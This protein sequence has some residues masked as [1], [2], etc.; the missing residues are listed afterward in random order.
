MGPSSEGR[1]D[2]HA[3][4]LDGGGDHVSEGLEDGGRSRRHR[5]RSPKRGQ[6]AA[7]EQGMR[8]ED[9][10]VP[11]SP[12]PDVDKQAKREG[13]PR[14]T[15]PPKRL[16]VD[17]P[18]HMTDH[19]DDER[20]SLLEASGATLL[21]LK[22]GWDFSLE[23]HRDAAVRLLKKSKP[24][25]VIGCT[26]FQRRGSSTENSKH[27]NFLGQLH[28]M[29]EVEGRWYLHEHPATAT[30]AG[31]IQLHGDLKTEKTRVVRGS[32]AWREAVY[33]TN[34]TAVSD[35][36][37]RLGSRMH[38]Q[39]E[40]SRAI[41]LG[42]REGMRLHR[43]GLWKIAEVTTESTLSTNLPQSVDPEEELWASAWD[44]ITGHSLDPKEVARARG[45]EMQYIHDKR[46][47]TK[48]PR[49]RARQNGW[50]V[51]ATRWIDIDKGDPQNPNHRS[52][53]VAKEFRRGAQDGVFAA[54]PPLEAVR[55]LISDAATSD[56][57]H[58]AG[59]K[60]IMVND[61]A[62]AFFE[63]PAK[64]AV[65]V[66]LP[67]EALEEGEGDVVGYLQKSLYGTRDAAANF[68]A[69][70]KRFMLGL[71]FEQSQ[72]SASV[73]WHRA[74]G[75]RTLVHG[76]DFMTT[77]LRENTAWFR[78]KLEGRFELK[79]CIIGGAPDELREG[80]LLGR[81]IRWTPM[82]W[83]YE[84]DQRHAELIVRGLHL[85][86]AKGVRSPGEDEKAWEREE[87]EVPLP[88]DGIRT[89]RA[90]AARANYLAM[91][92]ADIQYAAKEVC[93]GMSAPNRGH[94]KSLRRLARYLIFAPRVVWKF[95]RQQSVEE[96]SAFSDS[97]WAGC[98]ET[99]R[100][101]SGGALLR[102]EHCLRTWS[103]TQRFVT[104]S[105][106]EA[107]LM[108]VLR[109]ATE[110][111]GLVQLAASWGL[112][113]RA[114]VHVDSS[115]ALAVASRKGNGRMR[116]VRIA[117]LWIQEAQERGLVECRA[118]ITPLTQ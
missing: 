23:R 75:L 99:G 19:S 85:E 93:R 87:N 115:A 59:E 104:L 46:V 39:E 90:L 91:D 112:N 17:D 18:D 92:R 5:S 49:A 21:N 110:A 113:F 94:L 89:Y 9:V 41:D 72:Y 77:G 102:G 69:E 12:V 108:A 95:G 63:A 26:L 36:L 117:D 44:D 48:I 35:E 33:I 103:S 60:V 80:R 116:H 66:E 107:E 97:D 6:P 29:Q 2:V 101:T 73:F 78:K 58:G 31:L 47:W 20:L 27:T 22:V 88:Q 65:C 83:E 25:I 7:P 96:L 13:S 52:R 45:K 14:E 32:G 105:S 74:R 24:D 114:A 111:I 68:Q 81:V 11:D 1:G 67:A 16:R 109:S 42:V 56:V 55:L 64:R 28:R 62:R 15:E 79:T 84:A 100:S 50:P 43:S 34:C 82:G 3:R 57:G 4:D 76:D 54:T 86:G 53:L 118:S 61:I 8:G 98:K 106:A 40:A 70:V 38:I 37:S 10:P 30:K 51:I 71:G